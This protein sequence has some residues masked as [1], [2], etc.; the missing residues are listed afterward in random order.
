M[1][2]A[3]T[4]EEQ[5]QWMEQWRYTSEVLEEVRR[6]ELANL[7]DEQAWRDTEAL[8]TLPKPWRDPNRVCGLIEQQAWFARARRK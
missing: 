8:L 1:K 2:L 7:S 6:H 3:T 5:W 4:P